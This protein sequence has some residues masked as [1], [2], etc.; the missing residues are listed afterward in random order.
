MSIEFKLLQL[1][2]MKLNVRDSIEKKSNR[3]L[4]K[5]ESFKEAVLKITTI[6]PVKL[7]F[8]FFSSVTHSLWINIA[9]I[10]SVYFHVFW[11]LV[12]KV[13]V[14]WVVIDQDMG[15]SKNAKSADILGLNEMCGCNSISVNTVV[16]F[17]QFRTSITERVDTISISQTHIKVM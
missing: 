17:G 11:Q 8:L 15:P 1:T 5:S 3:K 6:S 14:R 2:F 10:V 13:M 16:F 7:Q 4:P 12:V 9:Q